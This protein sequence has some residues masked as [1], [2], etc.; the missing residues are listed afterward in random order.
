MKKEKIRIFLLGEL[1]DKIVVKGKARGTIYLIG[2]A[3]WANIKYEYLCAKI[4]VKTW[5]WAVRMR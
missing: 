5:Y 4:K 3:L 2:M 1:P